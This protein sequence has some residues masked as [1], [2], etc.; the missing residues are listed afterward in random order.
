[1]AND[2]NN[3]NNNNKRNLLLSAN[4][5]ASTNVQGMIDSAFMM[6]NDKVIDTEQAASFSTTA[7]TM[8]AAAAA[9][10]TNFADAASVKKQKGTVTRKLKFEGFT[11]KY[12]DERLR[13]RVNAVKELKI[14][15]DEHSFLRC[16][17]A[18]DYLMDIDV[19][20]NME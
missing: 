13:V 20:E 14:W 19:Y 6:Q 1:M 9:Q 12:S 16:K 4:L 3:N 11:Y 5:G 7:T 18:V 10:N 2:K 15:R 8:L 17:D